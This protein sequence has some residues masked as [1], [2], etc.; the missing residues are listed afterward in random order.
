MTPSKNNIVLVGAGGHAQSIL[1]I[2]TNDGTTIH[3]YCAPQRNHRLEAHYG[4]EYLGSDD[5]ILTATKEFELILG[6]SYL[7]QSVSGELRKKLLDKF[8]SFRF[9]RWI[10]HSSIVKTADIGQGSIVFERALVNTGTKIGENC[11]I[12][13]GAIVEHDCVIGNNVQI[14]P[15]AI[16]LGG[17]HIADNCFIGA[18]A[19]IRDSVHI[20]TETMIPMGAKVTQNIE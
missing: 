3:Q 17:V 15:G 19:I 8:Q 4:V 20:K 6:V 10:A 18:G 7:G 14:S 13:S 16:V 11:V 1:A 12:N 5:Q 9:R 2:E